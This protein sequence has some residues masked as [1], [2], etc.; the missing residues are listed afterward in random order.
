MTGVPARGGGAAA[1]LGFLGDFDRGVEDVGDGFAFDG[2]LHALE[3]GVGV[4]VLAPKLLALAVGTVAC[5]PACGIT[6]AVDTP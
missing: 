2:P 1:F 6:A 4:I 5:G 3:H